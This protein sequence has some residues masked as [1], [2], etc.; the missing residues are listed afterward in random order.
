[1]SNLEDL[2]QRV[3][4][5]EERLEMESGLRASADR[6]LSD[7][8]QTLRAQQGSIQALAVTQTEQTALLRQHNTKLTRHT[9]ILDRHTEALTSIRQDHGAKLTQIITMLDRLVE[10]EGG[11]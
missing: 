4:A 2:E 8:R 5:V 3:T 1:M 11:R 7:I 10:D 9:V 6:D